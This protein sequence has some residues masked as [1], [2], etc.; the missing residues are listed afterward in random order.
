MRPI[1]LTMSAF[2]PYADL[3]ELDFTTLGNHMLFLIC[4]P[5]GAGK[6]TILDAMCY[7]LYGITSGEMRTGESMRSSHATLERETYV[8]FDFC[9]GDK[10][11]RVHRSPTQQAKRKRG[12]TDL[13]LINIS[14]P[15]RH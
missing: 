12:D 2:G 14:E 8:E 11:Y 10:Y 3:Q 15:T 6:S 1:K 5:T 13:S 9:L 7:A 4:G